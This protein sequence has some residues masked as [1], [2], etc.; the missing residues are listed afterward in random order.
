MLPFI[1][2]FLLLSLPYFLFSSELTL[3]EDLIEKF[4]EEG[5]L[6]LILAM[7]SHVLGPNGNLKSDK[8]TI[9]EIYY[10]ILENQ[11]PEDF[12]KGVPEKNCSKKVALVGHKE[13]S[14]LIEGYFGLL[15]AVFS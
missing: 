4:S 3:Q 6:D 12:L 7:T 9:L 15:F 1:L 5:V 13:I 2:L 14:L 8:F 11:N 10:L